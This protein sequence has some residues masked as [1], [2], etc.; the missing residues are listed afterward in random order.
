MTTTQPTHR[1]AALAAIARDSLNIETLET[2]R[3][4][5]LDFHD[6]AVGSIREA[7]ELAFAAGQRAA[8]GATP[9]DGHDAL[10]R[11]TNALLEARKNQMVTGVEWRDLRIALKRARKPH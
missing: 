4:D 9:R 3:S 10:V 11:A 1:D 7:L 5:R 6:L 2:R 8:L